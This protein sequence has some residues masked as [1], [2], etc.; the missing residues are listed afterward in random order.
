MLV[1]TD[2]RVTIVK[3]DVINLRKLV[4]MYLKLRITTHRVVITDIEDGIL[5][6]YVM[7]R[8][9]FLLDLKHSILRLCKANI[10][11]HRREDVPIRTVVAIAIEIQHEGGI[12]DGNVTMLEPSNSGHQINQGMLVIKQIIAAKKLIPIRVRISNSKK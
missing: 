3:P 4:K 10:V 6:M 7:G 12:K 5:E 1:D 8:Y 11:F 9:G 2:V